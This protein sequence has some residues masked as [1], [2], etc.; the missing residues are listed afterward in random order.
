MKIHA[1]SL[2]C[3][4]ALVSSGIAYAAEDQAARFAEHKAEMLK[5]LNEEKAMLDQAINCVSSAQNRDDF[6]KCHEAKRASMKA[7]H[8][9]ERAQ[10][11]EH[12]QN[13]I[14][15][16]DSEPQEPQTQN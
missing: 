13:E 2:I 12:L 7:M 11:K 14:K 3:S 8:E 4:V 9:R 10:R 1:I 15:K 16:L 6:K 5:N